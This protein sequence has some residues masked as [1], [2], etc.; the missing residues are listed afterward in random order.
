[1]FKVIFDFLTEPLGLPIEWYWEYLILAVIGLIAYVIAFR[2]VGDMYDSGAISGSVA[3]SYFHWLIRLIFFA[4]IW[5]ITYGVIVAVKWLCANW[6]LALCILGGIVLAVGILTGVFL[7]R[8]KRK[9]KEVA[10][11]AGNEG[12]RD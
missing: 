2:A 11:D 7:L 3:G 12:Q 8:Q 6:I 9:K 4:V 10:E 5:A 1:M